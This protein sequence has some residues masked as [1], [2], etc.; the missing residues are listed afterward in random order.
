MK[1]YDYAEQCYINSVYFNK[2]PQFTL[3]K[4]K[5]FCAKVILITGE[6]NTIQYNT[7]EHKRNERKRV[8]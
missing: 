2:V 7:I 3:L 1:L 8:E 4:S 6:Y 5:V